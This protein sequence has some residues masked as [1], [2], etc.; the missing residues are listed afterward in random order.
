MQPSS[1]SLLKL[2][3]NKIP[4][5]SD[6]KYP[7]Y[8]GVEKIMNSMFVKDFHKNLIIP[9]PLIAFFKWNMELMNKC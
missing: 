7:Y 8:K 1:F 9:I 5:T 6:F 3:I 2:I 4:D